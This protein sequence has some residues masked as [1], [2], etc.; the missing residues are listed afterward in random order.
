[1]GNQVFGH[2][3]QAWTVYQQ[4]ILRLPYRVI[5]QVMEHLFG[6]G[7]CTSSVVNFLG[8][9]ATYY[10]PTGRTSPG[11]LEEPLRPRR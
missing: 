8:Y 6:V 10:A 4:V 7:L 2:G 9:L 5:V 11:N 3:F 1:M